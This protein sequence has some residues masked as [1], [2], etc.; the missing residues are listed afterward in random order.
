MMRS[1]R[2]LGEVSAR[3]LRP[4]NPTDGCNRKD[5]AINERLLSQTETAGQLTAHLHPNA[6]N[7]ETGALAVKHLLDTFALMVSLQTAYIAK[8]GKVRDVNREASDDEELAGGGDG[9]G[10]DGE[11]GAGS[12]GNPATGLRLR[13]APGGPASMSARALPRTFALFR[14]V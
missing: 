5:R 2:G 4:L 9:H 3:S 11:G 10:T 12:A 8:G 14:Q 6:E 1:R 7:S 13:R